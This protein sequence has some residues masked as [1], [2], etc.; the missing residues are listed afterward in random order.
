MCFKCK[1]F[2]QLFLHR[3]GHYLLTVIIITLPHGQ[4]FIGSYSP[5]PKIVDLRIFQEGEVGVLTYCGD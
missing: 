1:P 5:P 4:T 2:P 3:F